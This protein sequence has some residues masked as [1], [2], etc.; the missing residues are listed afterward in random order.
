MTE[1]T[2]A[3]GLVLV[4]CS[5]DAVKPKSAAPRDASADQSASAPATC[6]TNV[7]DACPA[8]QPSYAADVV[9]I[10]NAKC[11]GCH[12]GGDGSPWPLTNHEDVVHWRAFI[13]KD[14]A[15]CTMPPPTST[16]R[17]TEAEQS[18]LVTWLVCGAPEN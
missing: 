9:P 18:T 7:S 15:G 14:L 16:V 12:T 5:T 17:L 6:P 2:L 10:L 13:L 8:A 11:N 3:L 4:A 1:F